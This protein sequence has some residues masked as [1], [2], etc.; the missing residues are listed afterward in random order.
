MPQNTPNFT[1]PPP[2]KALIGA[3]PQISV[4][5]IGASPLD[6]QAP[7]YAALLK[8][9]DVDLV[10]FEPHAESL[11]ALN[12]AKGPHETYLPYAVGD[13]KIHTLKIGRVPGMSSLFEPNPAVMNLFHLF[14]YWS[15][16][17]STT[18][19][20]TVRLDDIPETIGTD[21]IKID[22]QGAELMALS[23]AVQRLRSVSVIHAEVS[24]LPMYKGQPLFSEVEMFLR[25]QGFMFHRFFPL[26]SR[27]I[28]PFF[29]DNDVYGGFS[30][31]LQADAIFVRDFARIALLNE[32]QLMATAVIL[33]DCYHSLDAVLFVLREFDRRYGRDLGQRYIEALQP[34]F[35]GHLLWAWNGP[36]KAPA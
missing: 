17:V 31:V 34:Y 16:V 14:P 15:K 4:T 36:Q 5:D 25:Q 10:G 23:G 28:S 11:A 9:G 32:A 18:D 2:F 33:H 13:G 3:I 12:A 1:P 7:P 30:Q 35:P 29:V 21:F 22:I 20:K 26:N 8:A 27:T 6:G 24:F 19:V